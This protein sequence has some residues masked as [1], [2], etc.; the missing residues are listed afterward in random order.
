MSAINKLVRKNIVELKP[1]SS[2]R[3]EFSATADVYLDAN[4]NPYQ[5]DYNR[6]PD[7]HQK[8]VKEKLALIK[9][10]NP[11]Q[12]FLGNGS[13]EAIDLLIRIFCEPANDSILITEPTYG[14]YSV[15]AGVNNVKVDSITLTENFELV[16]ETL[17][18][19]FK[20]TTKLIFLCS[21]NNPSGN[22]LNKES[23]TKILSQFKG[24]IVIDEAYID[25]ANDEGF[26]PVLNQFPNLVILQT[27]SK[28]WGLAGLRLGMA[29]ASSEIIT[30]MNK[31]KYP[32][33]V[34]VV[35]QQLALD[36]LN[37][38]QTKNSWVTEIIAE[39]ERV[40]KEIVKIKG[41][42]KVY[43]SDAN[44]ILV[45]I[46]NANEVYSALLKNRIIVRNRSNIILC[47]N[48]LRIT[49]GTPDENNQLL[50]TLMNL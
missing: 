49:I 33:N 41:V 30:L 4:E 14:M 36:S 43:Q 16:A 27:F 7:P 19:E 34:N 10:V 32:Y 23:I 20:P 12:I 9:N 26:L 1:Y 13:D 21:P 48:C 44:F 3:D 24:I 31:V 18:A 28:A 42:Q 22:L 29:F 25:F 15:C 39:R 5:S 11:N 47:A 45:K 35:T 8:K 46:V 50:N 38:I 40:K 17:L 6:Y 2:A 37:T